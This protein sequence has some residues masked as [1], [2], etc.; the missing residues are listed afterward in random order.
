MANLYNNTP[1]VV[2]LK[3]EE[4]SKLNGNELKV[5]VDRPDFHNKVYF[6]AFYAP[7][8]GHCVRMVDDV[9]ALAKALKNEGFLVGTVNCDANQEKL[10]KKGINISSFPTLYFVKD[11]VPIRYEG[12]RD[13]D[14]LLSHLCSNLGKCMRKN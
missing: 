4:L 9:K 14:S 8:C 3:A 11:N 1:G 5:I 7:W 10:D 12:A 13:L 6:L 2:E